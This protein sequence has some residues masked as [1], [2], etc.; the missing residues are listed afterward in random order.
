MLRDA[1]RWP[2][3]AEAYKRA[4]QRC[5]DIG[6]AKGHTDFR[7]GSTGQEMFDWWVGGGSLDEEDGGQMGLFE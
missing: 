6:K 5:I 7:S 1:A 4:F 3:I 2:K